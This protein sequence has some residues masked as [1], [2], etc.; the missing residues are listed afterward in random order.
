MIDLP[1]ITWDLGTDVSERSTVKTE[2]DNV[3]LENMYTKMQARMNGKKL[4]YFIEMH[5]MTCGYALFNQSCIEQKLSYL[6]YVLY[7]FNAGKINSLSHAYDV[8]TRSLDKKSIFRRKGKD[9]FSEL[10][11]LSNYIIDTSDNKPFMFIDKFKEF[12]YCHFKHAQFE[13]D[14]SMSISEHH[15]LSIINNIDSYD[16]ESFK[17]WVKHTR[18]RPHSYALTDLVKARLRLLG[19]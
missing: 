8:S 1:Q 17:T 18:D 11:N 2:Q 9:Y 15:A 6:E 5:K 13:R 14:L 12:K 19:Y 4:L 7:M 16:D 10:K 3:H